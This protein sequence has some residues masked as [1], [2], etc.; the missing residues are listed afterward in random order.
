MSCKGKARETFGSRFAVIMAMA[1]SAIGLGN[2]WRFPY[3]VGE[4]GGAAFIL[5]YVLCTFLLALPIFLSESI[6][7]RR[8]GSN[9]FGAM[10]KLAPGTSWKWM[11]LLTV[12]SPVVILSYYS[13][14]GGWSVEYLFKSLAFE[15]TNTPADNV[16]RLF[17]TCITSSWEPLFMLGLFLMM[18]A[19]IVLA[20]VK[21]GIERFSKITM[22]VLFLL[23]VVM[24]VYSVTRSARRRSPRIRSCVYSR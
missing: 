23:I 16:P 6:I 20:G 19:G 17:G 14:V 15:F 4:Y 3:V 10:E 2:I 21:S 9:T 13:V 24:L 5:V 11:G 7:G 12:I 22:P 1:G 8:S 18:V